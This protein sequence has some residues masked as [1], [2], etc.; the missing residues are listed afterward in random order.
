MSGFRSSLAAK[1]RGQCALFVLC[2]IAAV[3]SLGA[4]S[5]G[6][7]PAPNVGD[8]GALNAVCCNGGRCNAGM[9]CAGGL[10]LPCGGEGQDCCSNAACN[11]ALKCR[12]GSCGK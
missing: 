12:N 10:C 9:V 7:T 5:D 3:S 4:G 6:G 11:S 2:L 8:C 1:G